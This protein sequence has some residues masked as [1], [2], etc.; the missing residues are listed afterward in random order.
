M[1]D[2]GRAIDAVV[3]IGVINA[4]DACAVKCTTCQTIIAGKES[5]T[6]CAVGTGVTNSASIVVVTGGGVRNRTAGVEFGVAEV[7]RA[8]IAIAA[9]R[10]RCARTNAAEADLLT[11]A[12]D[13]VVAVSVATAGPFQ[14]AVPP[15]GLC[16]VGETTNCQKC[17]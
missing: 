17:Q 16:Y 1:T 6:T 11:V 10:N 8:R 4:L 2:V 9:A 13:A 3:T 14:A 15:L 7:I 12:E 5:S